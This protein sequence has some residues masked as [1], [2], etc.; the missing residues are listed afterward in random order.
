[1]SNRNYNVLLM[2]LSKELAEI[3][4]IDAVILHGSF[5]RGDYGPKSDID[6]LLIAERGIAREKLM[7]LIRTHEKKLGRAI[8]LDVITPAEFSGAPQFVFNVLAE[9]KVLYKN[10]GRDFQIP[11]SLLEMWKPMACYSLSHTSAKLSRALRGYESKKGK[12]RYKYKGAIEAHGGKILAKGVFLAPTTEEK[13]FD[14]LLKEHGAKY[15][16]EMILYAFSG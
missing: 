16:K 13:F 3:D 14:E 9:G 5:A 8:T 11:A 2:K 7:K 10:P 4:A 1:M 12:Y 6:L 15:K